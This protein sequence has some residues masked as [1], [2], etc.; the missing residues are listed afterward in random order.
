MGSASPQKAE[1]SS[2]E[3]SQASAASSSRSIYSFWGNGAGPSQPPPPPPPAKRK[4]KKADDGA[5]QAK[6]GLSA[7]GEKTWVINK[8]VPSVA[9]EETSVQPKGKGKAR[10]KQSGEEDEL[11]EMAKRAK[12]ASAGIKGNTRG[13]KCPPGSPDAEVSRITGENSLYFGQTDGR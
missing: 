6:I 3:A 4:R 1:I 2:Q 8:D 7:G 12:Q 10:A 13:R 11:K 5:S 9:A